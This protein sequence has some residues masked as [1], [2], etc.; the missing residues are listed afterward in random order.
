MKY[1]SGAMALASVALVSCSPEKFDGLDENGRPS[2]GDL[3]V[4]IVLDQEIN[5]YTLTLK[6]PGMYPVWRV[7]ANPTKPTISTRNGLTGI[8]PVAGTYTV[9]VQA[10]NY[11]GVSEG[12]LTLEMTFT[13]SKIDYA[14]YIRNLTD[15]AT[16][17]WQFASDQPAHLGCGESGSDGTGWWSA[18]PEE[19]A[20]TGMYD[21]SFIFTQT[22]NTSGGDYTFD[23]GQSGTIY[24]NTGVT[25]CPPYSASNPNDGND[26]TAPA[27][28]QNTTFEFVT[29][30]TDLF[31][32]FPAGT[33]LGYLP[34]RQCFDNPKFKV[35]ELTRSRMDLTYDNGEIA[36]HYLFG[37]PGA[38]E[39]TGFKY[40]SQFNMWKDASV[41]APTFYYAPGWSQLPDPEYSHD[42][43]KLYTVTLPTATTD[44]WQAQMA[45]IADIQT[46]AAN[47][48]DFSCIINSSTDHPGMTV[49]LCKGEG[50]DDDDSQFIF[51]EHGVKLEAGQNYVFYV[52]DRPGVDAQKLKLVFDFG[53]NADNTVMTMSDIVIKNH[54]DDDGTVLPSEPDKPTVEWREADNLWAPVNPA[55]F[56]YYYAPGWNQIDNPSITE[57]GNNSYTWDFPLA[58]T[59]QWQAQV[60]IGSTTST[61]ADKK[62]DFRVVLESNQDFLGA[63]IKFVKP[64][65]GDNDN[66]FF[67]ADRNALVAGEENVFEWVALDGIDIQDLLLVFDFG[68]C[69]DGTV[70]TAKDIIVQEHIE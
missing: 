25:D 66:I 34:N 28:I 64:G 47:N 54:A 15:N 27:Q 60:K 12:V 1:I 67:M 29:E 56:V 5:Q 18:Q 70:I 55:D 30:G 40:D 7:Y 53:G 16:K 13:D 39:F 41:S 44:T 50:A 43:N 14:P 36:W 61:S 9:E 24:V 58:T 26:Y 10:G 59:D 46:S 42:G 48:Y 37:Q 8:I 17:T 45:M 52:S 19:K 65:G 32:V 4:E 21:N 20:S 11:N 31:L 35:N 63:T 38:P 23:P 2:V 57:N 68:G 69:P 3:Q 49:K 22:D 6:N 33:L 62:Y 51:E